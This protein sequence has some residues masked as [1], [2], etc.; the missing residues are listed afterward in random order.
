MEEI[1]V[2]RFGLHGAVRERRRNDGRVERNSSRGERG[3]RTHGRRR[4]EHAVLGV[5]AAAARWVQMADPGGAGLVPG[6][7]QQRVDFL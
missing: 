6:W 2:G 4:D 1:G 3:E 5:R 7:V